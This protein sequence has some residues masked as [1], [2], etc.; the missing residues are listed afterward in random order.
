MEKVLGETDRIYPR[1]DYHLK[2]N[3]P[4]KGFAQF[5][6]MFNILPRVSTAYVLKTRADQVF[7][8]LDYVIDLMMKNEKVVIFPY[9]I[10]GGL[11]CKYHPS[12]QMFGCT[13]KKMKAIWLPYH[14]IHLNHQ[15]IEIA[16]WMG[17]MCEQSADMVKKHGGKHVS[18]M[19]AHEYGE[20]CSKLFIVINEKKIQPYKVAGRLNYACVKEKRPY[21]E[22]ESLEKN[23]YNFFSTKG[24]DVK[25]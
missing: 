12:D 21:N 20:F 4:K 9:Y 14:Q 2:K 10:R 6:H 25:Y 7:S 15:L 18:Q 17:W 11:A 3:L 19:D 24:C 23:T 1:K 22:N 16:V 5:H 13:T 8:N